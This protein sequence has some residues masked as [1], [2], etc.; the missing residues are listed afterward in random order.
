[1]VS[2]L[3]EDNSPATHMKVSMKEPTVPVY[4]QIISHE[5][6]ILLWPPYHKPYHL[7]LT[8]YGVDGTEPVPPRSVQFMGQAVG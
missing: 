5:E 4:P 6:S 3:L 8:G 2:A 1:M 7:D